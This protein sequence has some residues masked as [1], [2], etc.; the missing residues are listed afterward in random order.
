[1]S[2]HQPVLEQEVL[3]GFSAPSTWRGTLVD[4]T[5]G[6]GG[7]TGSLLQKYPECK[8][9]GLDQDSKALEAG[10]QKFENEIRTGR[11]TLMKGRFSDIQKLTEGLSV[12]GILADLGYSSDQLEDPLRG[13]S[14][15]TD[16]P[17]DMRLSELSSH[18]A[19]DLLLELS[20]KEIADLIFQFGDERL[21]RRIARRIIDAR[22]KEGIPNSTAWLSNL[23]FHSYPPPQRHGRIHPATRTFQALRIAVNDELGELDRLLEH[24]IMTLSPGGRMAIISFHSL[25]DRKVKQM[26]QARSKEGVLK[27]MTKKPVVA[28]EAE[29]KANPR[30]R[31][32]KL[33]VAEKI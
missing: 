21:S 27:L 4:C 10:R 9:L 32:A 26:F 31:S 14:F 23:V 12:S 33:R 28:S 25:E 19:R 24:G 29:E 8:I 11:L 20:E 3:E 17:L 5:F 16:G 30:S 2:M 7:H 18:T 22:L 15:Q 1:M 13:L 6:G